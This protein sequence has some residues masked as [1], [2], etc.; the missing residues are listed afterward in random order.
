MEKE[1]RQQIFDS[2]MGITKEDNTVED[3]IKK[4]ILRTLKNIKI[5]ARKNKVCKRKA[6]GCA[7]LEVDLQNEAIAFYTAING[8]SG[9]K[10]KCSGIKG[11]CGCSHA[12]P[13]AIMK[14]LKAR[15]L[16]IRKPY[17]KTVLLTTFSSCVNCAN[18]II[19]SKVIDAVVYEMIAPHW[20]VE[21]NNA[22]AMLDR[23]LL[24]C[25]KKEIIDDVSN[26]LLRTWLFDAQISTTSLP[27]LES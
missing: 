9:S 16:K 7:I 8:P 22:K 25:S 19:D 11:A 4:A 24:H 18:I 20:A 10:N 26:S 21:P 23:S 15:R 14:Y 12:E 5:E 1:L 6:C 13:R 17:I 3:V 2:L 27:K